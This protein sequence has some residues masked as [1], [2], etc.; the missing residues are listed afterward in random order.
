MMPYVCSAVLCCVGPC[1]EC[2]SLSELN[3]IFGIRMEIWQSGSGQFKFISRLSLSILNH[4]HGIHSFLKRSSLNFSLIGVKSKKTNENQFDVIIFI[5][6]NFYCIEFYFLFFCFDWC[7]FPAI[8][9]IPTHSPIAIAT[10]HEPKGSI[11]SDD[12]GRSG[13]GLTTSGSIMIQF[14]IWWWWQ[15]WGLRV[16]MMLKGAYFCTHKA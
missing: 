8:P 16:D 7:L 1:C 3:T 10:S 4:C 6:I 12:D 13:G 5:A 15:W 2:L 14:N 9:Y 11:D